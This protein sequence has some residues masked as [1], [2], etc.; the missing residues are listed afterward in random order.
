MEDLLFFMLYF[1]LLGDLRI[2]RYRLCI[3]IQ[4]RNIAL[5]YNSH[6]KSVKFH[7][8]AVKLQKCSVVYDTTAFHRHRDD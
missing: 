6:K 2:E 3:T 5:F 8:F 1:L 7:S 4:P